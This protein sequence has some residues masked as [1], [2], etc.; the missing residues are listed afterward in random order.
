VVQV[1]VDERDEG[2]VRGR[3][4][5]E[6]ARE[7]Q[8]DVL[9]RQ[10]LRSTAACAGALHAQHR[11]DRR[12]A[13]RDDRS[14]SGPGERVGKPDRHRRLALAG[15]RGAHSAHEHESAESTRRQLRDIHLRDVSA[16]WFERVRWNP[17]LLGDL[18][19]RTQLRC[20]GECEI[21][22][23]HSFVSCV[24]GIASPRDCWPRYRPHA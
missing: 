10:N 7:V 1:I 24:T 9:H 8:V 6:V 23:S 20:A 16:V 2:V 13:Q 19:D 4:R 11:P 17:D 15:R 14:A 21:V 18:L 5:V 12:L 3:D 22:H